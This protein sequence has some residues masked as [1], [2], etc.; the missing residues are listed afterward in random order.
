MSS[1]KVRKVQREANSSTVE[2]HLVLRLVDKLEKFGVNSVVK[3]AVIIEK[4]I[5]DKT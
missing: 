2:Y 1:L 4:S 5:L 3:V